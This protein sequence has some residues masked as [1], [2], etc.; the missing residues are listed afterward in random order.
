MPAF[1]IYLV[2][3]ACKRDARFDVTEDNFPIFFV[4]G[5]KECKESVRFSGP[6][7]RGQTVFSYGDINQV[8]VIPLLRAAVTCW[9]NP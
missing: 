5:C 9:Y 1:S 4:V 7:G 3:D 6:E 8:R 2:C